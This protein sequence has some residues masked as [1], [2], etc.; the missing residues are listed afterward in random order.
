MKGIIATACLLIG[1]SAPEAV[2]QTAPAAEGPAPPWELLR[3][4]TGESRWEPLFRMRGA[5]SQY[6]DTAW[7]SG[8]AQMRAH[9]E[10]E[11]GD[12]AAALAAW[13]SGTSPRDSIGTLPPAI[14]ARDAVAYLG[15][16][17]DTARVIMINE[18]HHAAAD[19][20]LTLE[21][22][23]VLW[24]K[25]FRY[26]AAEAF[27]P[28]DT[29]LNA[30]GYP[31]EAS[32]SYVRDPVFSA[33]VREACQLGYTLVPYEHPS[34]DDDD[35][36]EL[37]P[38]Q[39]RD[40]GQARNLAAATIERDPG[41]KVFVHA[42]YSHV[43]ETASERFYPMALYFRELTGIDPV[44]VDQTRLS[45]RSEP[46][47]EHPAY[48]AG[49][50]AGLLDDGPAVLVDATGRTYSPVDFAVDIQVLTP[51]TTTSDGRPEWM[52][53]GGRRTAVAVEIPEGGE[54]WCLVEARL[55]SEPPEAN[56]LD[57][58][59]VRETER[60]QLYLPPGEE[61]VIQVLGADGAVLRTVTLP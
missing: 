38:Q 26:F 12:H 33:V 29:E 6:R 9:V 25:G 54:Q 24:D 48:R 16:V 5:E 8:Y 59:E 22:L 49:V 2:S 7:W 41:A 46:G 42:G 44:T 28:A 15:N 18:R 35:G 23:S 52:S 56:P 57:R 51:R 34:K 17:A 14:E 60:A 50:A 13:D 55:A 27:D 53:L 37:T 47:W 58:V 4:E 31:V 39:R 3:Q 19:R 20:L 30:R 1:S 61:V 32:G 21:L 10:A 11:V 36:D 45:E 43:L 40:L